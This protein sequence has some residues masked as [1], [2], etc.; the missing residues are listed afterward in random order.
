MLRLV[1]V[2]K[3]P[4]LTTIAF[5]VCAHVY[6]LLYRIFVIQ[7]KII[8]RY[9]MRLRTRALGLVCVSIYMCT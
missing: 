1:H 5:N 4:I 7:D 2:S 3:L 6:L 8:D 9:V